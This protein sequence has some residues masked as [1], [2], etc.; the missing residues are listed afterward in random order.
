MCD[1]DDSRSR[2]MAL[3]KMCLLREG[4]V[5]GM[6]VPFTLAWDLCFARRPCQPEGYEV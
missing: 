5:R 1:S 3:Q 6:V 4:K 2:L